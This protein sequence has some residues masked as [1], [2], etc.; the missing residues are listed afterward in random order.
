MA[1]VFDGSPR[2]DRSSGDSYPNGDGPH[3]RPS[4]LDSVRFVEGPGNSNIRTI[5][6]QRV[7]DWIKERTP[8]WVVFP[9]FAL[10]FM[11]PVVPLLLLASIPVIYIAT[12]G[13]GA[14]LDKACA[15]DSVFIR[16]DLLVDKQEFWEGHIRD[17]DGQ[18]RDQEEMP[19]RIAEDI[20]KKQKWVEEQLKD[21]PFVDRRTDAQKQADALRRQ[22]DAIEDAE[23]D[24]R[25]NAERLARIANLKACRAAASVQLKAP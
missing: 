9:F 8:V 18:I 20:A 13:A 10:F 3:R 23:S 12:S 14:T 6:V 16:Y 17:L 4:L 22:A 1:I 21:V 11:L 25:W 7:L 24:A 2:N 15:Q 19:A 5:A